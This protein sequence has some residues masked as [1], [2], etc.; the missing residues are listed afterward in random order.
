LLS[1]SGFDPTFVVGGELFFG[2][3]R[4][5]FVEDALRDETTVRRPI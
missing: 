2:K 1:A 4:L 5:Q 3:D